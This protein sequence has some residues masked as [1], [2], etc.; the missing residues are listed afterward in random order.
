[1]PKAL[2][3]GIKAA[4]TPSPLPIA[5]GFLQRKCTCGQPASASMECG[6][7]RR[8]SES[9]SPHAAVGPDTVDAVPVIVHEVLRSPGAPLDPAT[10][11][12]MEARF[13]HDFGRVRVHTD[14]RAAMSAQAVQALAY[15]VGRD[16]VFGAG[17]YAPT[18][19]I[20]RRLLAH[21]L[22][23]VVQQHGGLQ[24]SGSPRMA[25]QSAEARFERE[26]DRTAGEVV[27]GGSA[28]VRLHPAAPMIQRQAVPTG[29]KLAEAK[30]FGHGDLK[31]DELKKKYRTYIGS[32]TLMQVTPAGDYTGHCVK[33]Y[34]TEMA[35]TCPPRFAELR[36]GAFCTESKCLEFARY[37]T[38]G[39]ASTGKT[40]TDGPDTFIDRHRTSHDQSLLEGSGKDQCSVVCHQRY[41]FDRQHDLGSFY[42]VR[43]F[44]ASTYTPPGSTDALHITTGEVKK[45]PAALE[46]PG[47]K[48][49]AKDIAPELK[50]SGVLLEAPPLPKETEERK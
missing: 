15:T 29:I 48:K 27:Q 12:F 2:R 40:V 4:S 24:V 11:T 23:H 8:Q 33:E 42:V 49:F 13:G 32:T 16:V 37:G 47:K 18:T 38:A 17:Q 35:N 39:D 9:T 20:G 44:R 5:S 1:M 30:P 6:A 46:A 22:T 3:C 25:S 19:S 26:A 43:N 50:K 10:R 36:Q 7:C 34:L 14:A 28:Q 31:T 41:K 45:V 21:E